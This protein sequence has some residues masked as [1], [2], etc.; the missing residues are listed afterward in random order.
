MTTSFSPIGMSIETASTLLEAAGY[1]VRL[2]KQGKIH[3]FLTQDVKTNRVNLEAN[4]EGY[5]EAFFLG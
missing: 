5:V 2:A 3:Y 4:E 1:S